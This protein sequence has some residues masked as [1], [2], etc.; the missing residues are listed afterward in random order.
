MGKDTKTEEYYRKEM[1]VKF[2]MSFL[3][4]EWEFGK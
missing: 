4:S 2:D 1:S 3:G